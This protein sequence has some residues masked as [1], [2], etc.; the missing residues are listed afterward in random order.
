MSPVVRGL[1]AVSVLSVPPTLTHTVGDFS[2]GIQQRFGLPLLLAAF[3]LS[4]GYTAQVAAAALSARSDGLGHLLNFAVALVWFFGAVLDHL[5]EVLTV[6]TEQY[7]TGALSKGLE[8]GIML[9]AA[10]WAVLAIAAPRAG[11][12][13][14]A[15]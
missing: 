10:A 6:P 15:A 4:L 8:V 11:N 14:R 12:L 1:L 2:V 3:L 9:V 7:R 5:G 13:G